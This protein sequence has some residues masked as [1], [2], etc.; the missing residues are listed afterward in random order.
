M[1]Q[2]DAQKLKEKTLFL[3][4]E[5]LNLHN[6]STDIK[7]LTLNSFRPEFRDR[8]REAHLVLFTRKFEIRIFKHRERIYLK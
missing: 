7:K 8:I 6:V 3:G 2:T 4:H 5:H 1:E